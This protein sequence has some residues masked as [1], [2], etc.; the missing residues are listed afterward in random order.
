MNENNQSHFHEDGRQT[1]LAD[2][3]FCDF[4]SLVYSIPI[5]SD[6]AFKISNAKNG[7]LKKDPN[8]RLAFLP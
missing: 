2:H 3:E 7:Y 5:N 1:K 4:G 6:L 8:I